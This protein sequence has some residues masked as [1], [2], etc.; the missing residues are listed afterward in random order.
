MRRRQLIGVVG[1]VAL[2]G[3]VDQSLETEQETSD[4]DEQTDEDEERM[5]VFELGRWTWGLIR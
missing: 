1:A 5:R 4:N 3:C 2:S